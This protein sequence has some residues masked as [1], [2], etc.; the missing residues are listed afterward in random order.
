MEHRHEQ[1]VSAA[2]DKKSSALLALAW[3]GIAALALLAIV[4]AAGILGTNAEGA[5]SISWVSIICLVLCLAAAI[6][7]WRVKDRLRTEY[8]Y[9]ISDGRLEVSAVL[10]NRR[11][12]TKLSLELGRI[13][14]CGQGNAPQG[15]TDKF[16]L[17]P[18]AQPCYICYEEK[19]EKKIALLELNTDMIALLKNSREL[20]RGAWR[21]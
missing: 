8:D 10:N 1:T 2:P 3:F 5:L 20:Q 16:Y 4:F 7:I 17:D 11:R 21:G 13:L 19:G 14:A 12:V 18:N 15:S 6:L 9:V